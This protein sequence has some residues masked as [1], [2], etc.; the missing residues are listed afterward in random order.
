MEKL[1]KKISSAQKALHTLNEILDTEK[2][3]IVRD[4]SI[5]RFEY[6]FET[7]W[8]A[9]KSYLRAREGIKANSPKSIFRELG[10]VNILTEEQVELALQM[11]DD[12]N[13]TSHTYIEE[14]AEQIYAK[15]TEYYHLMKLILNHINKP[16]E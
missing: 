5:Q 4:A 15:L 8:K 2:T 11:T 13:M 16:A 12:R 1:N 14:V 9:A 10:S 7:A 3:I 6:S